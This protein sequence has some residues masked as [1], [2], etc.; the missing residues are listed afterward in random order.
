MSKLAKTKIGKMIINNKFLFFIYK[1]TMGRL[2]R[3]IR[4]KKRSRDVKENGI[5]RIME[6][7]QL[8]E[9]TPAVFFVDCGTL[10]GCVRD[11]KLIKWDYDVDFGIYISD[12]FGWKELEIEMK[13]IGF[14]LHHQ[15]CF[16]G[17]VTEQTYKKNT[18][19]IDFFGHFDDG[20]NTCYY[21]Y[22]RLEDYKYTSENEMSVLKFKTVKLTGIKKI[23]IEGGYVHIPNE[24]EE[25]LAGLYGETWR[26]PDPNWKGGSGPACIHLSDDYKAE[27]Q[28][29]IQD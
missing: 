1:A 8:L 20:D 6:I 5:L 15:F 12:I 10:L 11:H 14:D 4:L 27:L 28:K 19:M 25:Y 13:K 3:S 2:L 24:A 9:K 26:I 23:E 18:M 7:E 29:I 21:S 17:Q 16:Q 22:Y